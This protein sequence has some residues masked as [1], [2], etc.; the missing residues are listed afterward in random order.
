MK[1]I[2]TFIISILAISLLEACDQT[3]I[4][5]IETKTAVIEGYLFAGQTLDS[6]KISQSFSY[7]QSESEIVFLE[8]LDVTLSDGNSQYILTS[9]GNGIYQNTDV[10]LE[11]EK[12]Y[13]LE[14]TWEGK[15]VSADTY[16]PG[17]REAILSVPEI[18]VPKIEIGESNTILREIDPVEITWENN[19]GDYYYVLV[20]N[21]EDDPEYVNESSAVN[22]G[23]FRP[24][25][26][27]EPKITD[28]HEINVFRDLIQYGTYEVIVSRV[29][30]EYA[31]LY[32]SSGSSTISLEEVTTTNIKNGLGIFTGVSSDTLYLEVIKKLID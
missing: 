5:E 20:K 9:L 1:S 2:R 31:A 28:L 30:P 6:L 23:G 18:E 27:S 19:E 22:G 17:K 25:F 11:T 29:N 7:S 32:E 13:N 21:L 10:L 26:I 16:I 14:F 15:L 24:V 3:S 12:S 4:E 8:G